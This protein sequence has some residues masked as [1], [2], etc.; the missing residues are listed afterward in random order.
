MPRAGHQSAQ[1]ARR[2][3]KPT[4][5]NILA[6]SSM[7]DF[8]DV[9]QNIRDEVADLS[10]YFR[11]TAPK[12]PID[13]DIKVSRVSYALYLLDNLERSLRLAGNDKEDLGRFKAAKDA[14]T[15]FLSDPYFKKTPDEFLDAF[16]VVEAP[17]TE[18]FSKCGLKALDP[19]KAVAIWN[20]TLV[21]MV[22]TYNK[23]HGL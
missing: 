4:L 9:R 1:A 17:I 6:R 23:D 12:K 19:D 8:I 11:L 5:A 16:Y 21:A 22:E 14:V 20:H 18:C 3:P 2:G 15:W 13:F 10:V 7:T